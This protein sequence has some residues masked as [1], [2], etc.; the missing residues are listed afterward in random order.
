MSVIEDALHVRW[1]FRRAQ[2]IV[3][4]SSTQPKVF[5]ASGPTDPEVLVHSTPW[6]DIHGP[7]IVFLNPPTHTMCVSYH[8][9][10]Y[11]YDANALGRF[12]SR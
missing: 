12:Q 9:V 11:L 1:I 7:L 4:Q 2:T 6:W 8:V 5:P 3:T 10:T